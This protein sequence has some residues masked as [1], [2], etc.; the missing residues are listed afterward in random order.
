MN[1]RNEILVVRT[2]EEEADLVN[3]AKQHII[4][5]IRNN[6]FASIKEV[7]SMIGYI[8]PELKTV[9]DKAY[10]DEEVVAALNQRRM[11][12]VQATRLAQ[13][14]KIKKNLDSRSMESVL[15]QVA[16]DETLAR[17]NGG[18]LRMLDVRNVGSERHNIIISYPHGSA[19]I[20]DANIINDDGEEEKP[21][22]KLKIDGEG[23]E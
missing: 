6:I 18:G 15:R 2:D 1:E 4:L 17:L 3:K 11:E 23:E 16:E 7:R 14:E 20:E 5:T 13:I 22:L 10:D 9:Y 12:I 21:K 19:A 8:Q